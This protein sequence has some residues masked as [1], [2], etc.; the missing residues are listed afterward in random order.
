MDKKKLGKKKKCN[1]SNG[2]ENSEVEVW[3]DDGNWYRGWLS[4]FNV[5]TGKWIVKF[6][7]N[8]DTTEVKFPE[9]HVRLVEK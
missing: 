2:T 7:D 9:E 6:Y 3:Y 5:I 1:K 8:D 4:S